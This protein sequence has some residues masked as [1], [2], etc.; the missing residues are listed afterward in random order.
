MGFCVFTNPTLQD[1]VVRVLRK[2][3]TRK[4]VEYINRNMV[5]FVKPKK[6]MWLTF[7]C[8]GD[9]IY[10]VRSHNYILIFAEVEDIIM[11]ILNPSK[12]QNWKF[13]RHGTVR[14]TPDELFGLGMKFN[15]QK[16]TIGKL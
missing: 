9:V 7:L 16:V 6:P 3:F 2:L 1:N 12:T 10:D 13:W 15:H 4:C 11:D 8:P 5:G 14:K